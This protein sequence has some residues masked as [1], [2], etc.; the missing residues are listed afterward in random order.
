[1]GQLAGIK[2][3]PL[4]ESADAEVIARKQVVEMPDYYS[5][6]PLLEL[7]LIKMPRKLPITYSTNSDDDG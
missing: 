4:E 3:Y 2:V 1:V 5:P 6:K 7:R